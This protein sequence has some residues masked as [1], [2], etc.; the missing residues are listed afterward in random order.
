MSVL[1]CGSVMVAMELFRL[2]M[3]LD[4][5]AEEDAR[6]EIGQPRGIDVAG[7]V[8]PVVNPVHHP[9]EDVGG[10]AAVGTTLLWRRLFENR[11][12]QIDVAALDGT[13]ALGRRL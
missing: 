13:D 11:F 5:A 8:V 6:H 7:R 4:E 12:E 2:L 10:S 9:E 3:S 1:S